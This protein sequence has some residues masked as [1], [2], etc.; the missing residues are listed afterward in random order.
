VAQS[1]RT[2]RNAAIVL[3]HKK[4]RLMAFI[5]FGMIGLS[6]ILIINN[7]VKI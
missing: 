2:W 5:G 7:A 1:S 3:A 4:P 6:L